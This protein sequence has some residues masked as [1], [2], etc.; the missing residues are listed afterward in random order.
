MLQSAWPVQDA[1]AAVLQ[2]KIIPKKQI[3]TNREGLQMHILLKAIAP[4]TLCLEKDM[5]TQFDFSLYRSGKGKLNLMPI[6]EQDNS[7]LFKQPVQSVALKPGETFSYWIN[8]KRLKLADGEQWIPG[9][10]SVTAT[11]RLCDQVHPEAADSAS[12][13]T[14]IPAGQSTHFMIME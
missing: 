8:L 2:L 6:V 14:S 11:F 9:D 13:E 10:Y 7:V 12:R 4:V 5:F 3:Y 1:G